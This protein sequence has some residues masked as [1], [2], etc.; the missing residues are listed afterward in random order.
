MSERAYRCIPLMILIFAVLL[1]LPGVA[2]AQENPRAH[3][4]TAFEGVVV[5]PE[6]KSCGACTVAYQKCSATCFGG[7]KAGMGACLTAC[8]NA[9]VKCTCDQEVSVR[10][11]DLVNWGVVKV[12]KAAACHGNV[13]CQ[14]NYP[15]CASWSSY[16]DCEDPFCG[17][18]AHCGECVCDEFRCFCPPGPAWK[19]K[20]ERF[21]VCFD[22]FGNSCTEW[23]TIQ[24]FTCECP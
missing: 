8:D 18:G 16:S 1:A 3:P 4:G 17:S 15:S 12:T 21:R 5:P 10:S 13:S 22:Q 6:A 2:A 11:E 14:P 23:Q 9:A 20:Q 7:E 24:P 19:Q